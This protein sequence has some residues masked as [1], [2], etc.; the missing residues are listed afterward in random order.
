MKLKYGQ[1]RQ[2][3]RERYGSALVIAPVP[4]AVWFPPR[5]GLPGVV[6]APTLE[7]AEAMLGRLEERLNG[8]ADRG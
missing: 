4:G 8:G 5:D 3:A 2:L 1:L 7:E 6:V